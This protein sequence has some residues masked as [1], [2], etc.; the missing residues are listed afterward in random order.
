MRTSRPPVT[1]VFVLKAGSGGTSGIGLPGAVSWDTNC[2]VAMRR[3]L[4]STVIWK[5]RASRPR[6]GRPV[7]STTVASTATTS[8]PD[9]NTGG[10][11]GACDAAGVAGS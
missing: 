2:S 1:P 4:P 10:A 7:S 9:L 8:V 3:G 11:C 5:S 6:A